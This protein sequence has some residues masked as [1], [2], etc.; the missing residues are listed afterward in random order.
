MIPSPAPLLLPLCA[1]SKGEVGN[2]LESAGFSRAN[3]YYIVQQG[4]VSLRAL[5]PIVSCSR[6]I[7][8]RPVFGGRS[9]VPLTS[10]AI[11]S[12]PSCSLPPRSC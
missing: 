2:L 8:A 3:P 10:H 4:K 12:Q 1:R 9:R 6:E 5:T 7:R 11:P